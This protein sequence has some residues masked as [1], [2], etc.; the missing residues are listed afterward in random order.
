M[1]GSIFKSVA[2]NGRVSWRFQIDAGRDEDGNRIRVSE[3]GFRLEREAQNALSGKMQELRAGLVRTS[4][5]LKDYLERWLPYHAKAKP[6]SPT[7]AGRYESLAVHVTKALGAVPLKDLTPFVF[8]DLYVKLSGKLSAKTIREVHNVVHVALKRAVKT[9]LI[10]F[11]PADNCD[12]PRVDQKEAVALNADQLDAYQRAAAG[13]WAD[14]VIRL[15]AATGARRGELLACRWSDL[16]WTSS[17]LRIERSLYQVKKTVG[18]K[19]TKT[20]QARTVTVP[21][22]LIEYL[23]MHREQQNQNRAMFGQDYRADLDLVFCTP[24]GDFLKPDSVSWAARDIARQAGIKASL[25]SLRHTHASA[26]LAA[27]VPI[28][29]V[30]KRLGHRDSYTTAKIYQHALPDTDQDVAATWDKLMGEKRERKPVAQ[31][32]TNSEGEKGASDSKQRG[33]PG[34]PRGIRTPVTAVKGRCP[35]PLDDG[36]NCGVLPLQCSK[37][38]S[39]AAT[40]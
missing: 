37:C 20:R 40:C 15:A 6:L 30:S 10:P 31:N 11:N 27:G 14:L 3:S 7:T 19:P 21:A 36:D 2:P 25:H 9:K 39:F 35:R 8:D 23:K 34:V 17:K 24:A 1:K 26:L 38:R 33:K 16:D 13:K 28:A 4:A 12:L 32:G 5:T 18:L 29:N 22:S